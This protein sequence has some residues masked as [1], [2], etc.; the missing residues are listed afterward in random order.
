M[1]KSTELN[2]YLWKRM[3]DVQKCLFWDIPKQVQIS[4]IGSNNCMLEQVSGRCSTFANIWKKTQTV[5]ISWE[6][7]D[8]YGQEQQMNH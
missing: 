8:S 4:K 3:V 5:T 6:E 1:G 2:A 7:I